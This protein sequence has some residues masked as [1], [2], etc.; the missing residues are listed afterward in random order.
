[1]KALFVEWSLAVAST[2]IHNTFG[3]PQTVEQYQQWSHMLVT[4]P[5][6]ITF[7]DLHVIHFYT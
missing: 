7:K 1:M 3:Y 4:K 6:K 5:N 2:D